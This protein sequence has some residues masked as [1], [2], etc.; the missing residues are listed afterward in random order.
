MGPCAVVC[1]WESY[2]LMRKLPEKI[3]KAGGGDK[4]MKYVVEGGHTSSTWFQSSPERNNV[5]LR[6]YWRWW[7]LQ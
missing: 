5:K 2:S 7:Q 6:W 3:R 1:L 4:K